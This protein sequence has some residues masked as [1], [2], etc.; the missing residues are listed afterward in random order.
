M[1]DST[2]FFVHH[3]VR[4]KDAWA[5]LF[6]TIIE[7]NQGSYE[8]AAAKPIWKGNKCLLSFSSVDGSRTFCI[9]Q[10]EPGTS[11]S[12]FQAFIDDFNDCTA[13]NT[14]AKIVSMRG[15]EN[16]NFETLIHDLQKLGK[17]GHVHPYAGEGDLWF[18]RVNIQDKAKWDQLFTEKFTAMK[19]KSSATG[20]SEAL[21]LPHGVKNVLAIDLGD[22]EGKLTLAE[23][24]KDF[25]EEDFQRMV[26]NFTGEASKNDPIGKVNPVNALNS[27]LL[28]PDLY[29]QD[30]IAFAETI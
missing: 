21:R 28:H 8:E 7:E 13:K 1:T 6:E 20:I 9:W 16:L 15:G 24:P 5:K 22:G 25:T 12:D 17:D 3:Q 26:D 2:L 14:P 19:G 18:T 10:C 27:R 4:D 23:V 30:A 11:L 29:A